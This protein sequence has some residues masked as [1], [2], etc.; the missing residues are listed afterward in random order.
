M[1][2]GSSMP[3]KFP[4][5]FF[6]SAR[7]CWYVQL[8]KQQVKLHADEREA[9]KLYHELMTQR[10]LPVAERPVD[11][12]GLTAA[13]LFDKYLDWCAQ[14]RKPRTYD[15]YKDHLQSFL[16]ALPDPRMAAVSLRPFHIVEWADKHMTWCDC[17]RRG[18]IVAV[19]RPYNW[20]VKLAYIDTNPIA[21]IEKPLAKRR[22]T[23]V[24]PAEWAKIRDRYPEGDRSVPRR[25]R[26]AGSCAG[27]TRLSES[28]A[29]VRSCRWIGVEGA[30][31]GHTAQADEGL[32]I[33]RLAYPLRTAPLPGRGGE[34]TTAELSRRD[35]PADS[36]PQGV[37]PPV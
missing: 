35:K 7:N 12:G 6:R 13:E 2:E 4:K 20:A 11:F 25:P 26:T 8:G 16:A 29:S 9:L 14:H 28:C 19:Q 23:F 31:L 18:A 3:G 30:D 15:W 1:L 36:M 17:Q 21:H 32:V 34:E 10:A 5:P 27:F 37:L 33:G 22:E 24:T